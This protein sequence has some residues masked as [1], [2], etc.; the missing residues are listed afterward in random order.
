MVITMR[1]SSSD[2]KLIPDIASA[3]FSTSLI[4]QFFCQSLAEE[5][6]GVERILNELNLVS[7]P[8]SLFYDEKWH[9]T[10]RFKSLISSYG[11]TLQPYFGAAF[12]L[13]HVF[14][15]LTN[16]N[17]HLGSSLGD[18]F[19]YNPDKINFLKEFSSEMGWERGNENIKEGVGLI[20]SDRFAL[21]IGP[22]MESFRLA[23][24]IGHT[25]KHIVVLFQTSLE[26]KIFQK[27]HLNENNWS[28]KLNC[29]FTLLVFEDNSPDINS[30]DIFHALKNHLENEKVLLASKKMINIL[31]EELLPYT[32]SIHLLAECSEVNKFAHTLFLNLKNHIALPVNQYKNSNPILNLMILLNKPKGTCFDVAYDIFTFSKVCDLT[33]LD[34]ALIELF[35]REMDKKKNDDYP[36]SHYSDYVIAQL[37]SFLKCELTIEEF[38]QNLSEY[39]TGKLIEL[40]ISPNIDFDTLEYRIE[41]LVFCSADS[42]KILPEHLLQLETHFKQAMEKT[43]RNDIIHIEVDNNIN[44]TASQLFME[45]INMALKQKNGF[46]ST[47]DE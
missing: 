39:L 27:E 12:P 46:E 8:Y 38:K 6:K 20:I 30:N 22:E 26:C 2:T 36:S 45:R 15:V 33:Q 31:Q 32:E 18:I 25:F 35:K 47:H 16:I 17:M 28:V 40:I 19:T 10:D 42:T 34:S 4:N 37:V 21:N 3:N 11:I 43:A 44:V 1:D 14:N 7:L 29:P 5:I 41:Y 13:D 24:D 9:V 23:K